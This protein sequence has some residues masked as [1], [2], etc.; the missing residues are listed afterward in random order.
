[1]AMSIMPSSSSCTGE[2]PHP[3]GRYSPAQIQGTKTFCCTGNPE[4]RHISTSYVERQSV[5]VTWESPSSLTRDEARTEEIKLAAAIHLA[6]DEFEPCDLT[7]R[8]AVRPG[9]GQGC[10][11]RGALST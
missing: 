5:K 2:V 7:F 4:P 8:L 3:A 1:M 6:F 10:G 9:L 11:D